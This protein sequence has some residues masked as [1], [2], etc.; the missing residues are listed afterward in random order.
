[1]TPPPPEPDSTTHP[2]YCDIG[3]NLG[4]RRFAADRAAVVAR[5]Q[6]SGVQALIL[7]GTSVAESALAATL[8]SQFSGCR[9]TAGVHPHDAGNVSDDWLAQLRPLPRNAVAVGECGLDFDRDFSPRPAQLAVFEAQLA[10]AAELGKPLF[11][12]ERAAASAQLTLLRQWRPHGR[13]PNA[14]RR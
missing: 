7:T 8:A 14:G 12:H 2:R 5:A 3:V 13:R 9:Y 4:H 1:M 6:A 11:L 10:L